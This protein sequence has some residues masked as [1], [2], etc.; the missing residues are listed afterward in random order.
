ME[1]ELA[2]RPASSLRSMHSIDH[3]KSYLLAFEMLSERTSCRQL[4]RH[5]F[6]SHSLPGALFTV[7]SLQEG[8]GIRRIRRWETWLERAVAQAAGVGEEWGE[9][10]CGLVMLWRLVMHSINTPGWRWQGDQYG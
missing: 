3:F 9:E 8:V 10:M 2:S 7:G 6:P 4:A 5:A 1:H